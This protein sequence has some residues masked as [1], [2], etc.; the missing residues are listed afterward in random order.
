MSINHV[1]ARTLM[2]TCQP[3]YHH[4][5]IFSYCKQFFFYCS[6]W[7]TIHAFSV[8]ILK[9]IKLLSHCQQLITYTDGVWLIN[10]R[11]ALVWLRL[12]ILSFIRQKILYQSSS[13]GADW[14]LNIAGG[15]YAISHSGLSF[16]DMSI[17][18]FVHVAT[19][20]QQ[21]EP[22]PWT[23]TGPILLPLGPRSVTMCEW[24][25]KIALK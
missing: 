6:Q 8:L 12:L 25:C 16:G 18:T 17:K 21:P 14:T 24:F 13:V 7:G 19:R 4:R 11:R 9:C 5:M 15:C 3:H 20:T 23:D 2:Q 1:L 10:R 22:Q